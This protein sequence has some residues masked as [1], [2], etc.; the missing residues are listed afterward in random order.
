[1]TISSAGTQLNYFSTHVQIEESDIS[2][3]HLIG[4][5]F[6]TSES[7]ARGSGNLAFDGNSIYYTFWY[8]DTVLNS[9]QMAVFKYQQTN[10]DNQEMLILKYIGKSENREDAGIHMNTA[11]DHIIVY[12]LYTNDLSGFNEFLFC[13]AT[14]SLIPQQIKVIADPS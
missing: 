1:M 2:I 12:H 7:R 4:A 5:Y 13:R 6:D 3:D 9:R 10:P 11:K 8:H 14:T